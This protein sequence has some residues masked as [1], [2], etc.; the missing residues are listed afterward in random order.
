MNVKTMEGLAGASASIR[1]ISTPMSVADEAERKGDTDKMQRALGYAAGL[2]EQ[3]EEYG[4]KASQ[5][6]EI[7]AKEAKEKEKKLQEELKEARIAERKEQEERLQ[8]ARQDNSPQ[9][10][11]EISEAGKNQAA[12]QA[13]TSGPDCS[14]SGAS[15]PDVAYDPFG[16]VVEAV[17]ETG[18]NVDVSV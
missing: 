18:N 11:V 10:T 2:R 5:G 1:M 8:A 17:Q 6:M 14:D 16:E 15:V 4:E 7:E 12:A 13:G 3:A 9:D